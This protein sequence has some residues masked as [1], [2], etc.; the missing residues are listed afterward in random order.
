[1]EAISKEFQNSRVLVLGSSGFIGQALTSRLESLGSQLT[2]VGYRSKTEVQ[3]GAKT[4]SLDLN[5]RDRTKQVLSQC[6]PFDYIFNLSGY[7]DHSPFFKGGRKVFESHF[8]GLLNVLESID[9][10]SL[11]RFVQIGS[12]DE[13]GDLK[14]PQKEDVREKPISPY[15]FSKVAASHFL[16]MLSRT[17][18]F[19]TTHLRVFLAY[20]PGQKLPRLIPHVI[21]SSLQ[22]KEFPTSQGE[23][24]RDFCY[25]D[26]LTRGFLEAAVSPKTLGETLNLASGQ[27]IQIR[28]LIESIVKL[29][30]SGKPQFGK[31]PYRPGENMALYADIE[32]A[33]A[34]FEWQPQVSLEDGLKRTIEWFE[35]HCKSSDDLF[36]F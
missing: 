26:D 13:Y 11:K 6:G 19:P 8:L 33:K 30:G 1:M 7:I 18:N 28:E 5:D 31:V 9:R 35:G 32:K 27:G 29:I 15:A 25:I 16:E 36:I 24:L 34:L 23:Q 14:A 17:E 4:L 3:A 22:N 10:T 20:G 2:C 12:S 21:Q